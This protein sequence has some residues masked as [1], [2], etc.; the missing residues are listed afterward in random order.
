M[1]LGKR[2]TPAHAQNTADLG[3][4]ISQVGDHSQRHF[5][6]LVKTLGLRTSHVGVLRAIHAVSGQTQRELGTRIGM[7]ASNLVTLID[8]LEKRGL[9][10]RVSREA[11]RRSYRLM[12]TAEGERTVQHV[13]AKV[14]EH[15]SSLCAPLTLNEQEELHRLLQKIAV[16]RKLRPG[17]HPELSV[18]RKASSSERRERSSPGRPGRSR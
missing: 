15:R 8:E 5:A 1:P 9:V 12:L 7:F 16:A 11:D 18:G 3:F 4:L 13:L 10:E 2:I 17:I 6:A 14:R